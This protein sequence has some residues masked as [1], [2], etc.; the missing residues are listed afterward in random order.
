M[1]CTHR[2]E[3]SSPIPIYLG[4]CGTLIGIVIGVI[5]LGFGGGI[6]ALLTIPDTIGMAEDAAASVARE[7]QQLGAD[8]ISNLLRGI[9][10]AMTTTFCGVLLSIIGTINFRKSQVINEKNKNAFFSWIQAELLPKMDNSIASTLETLEKNL[11][12]FNSEFAGNSKGLTNIIGQIR[13]AATS[14]VEVYRQI[15]QL[16]I[17]RMANANVRVWQE[18]QNASDE[19]AQLHKFLF[20]SQQY[21]KHV[22]NLNDKLDENEGRTRLIEEMGQFFRTEIQEI[23]QRKVALSKSVGSVDD[24]MKTGLEELRKSIHDEYAKFVE[25]AG[26][27]QDKLSEAIDEQAQILSRKVEET[28]GLLDELKQLTSVKSAIESQSEAIGEQSEA[29]RKQSEAIV[30]M[31][32]QAEQKNKTVD[33]QTNLLR[34]ILQAQRTKAPAPSIPSTVQGGSTT[35][36]RQNL[37]IPAWVKVTGIATAAV[38]IGTCVVLLLAQFNII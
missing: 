5:M 2:L 25:V 14:Q 9:G 17:E 33:E 36:V 3:A 11:N 18:L 38:I 15:Q 7:S 12:K 35:I 30:N 34:Q 19:L 1:L 27:E 6:E 16:D 22:K 26:E 13:D 32:N 21:L 23:D 24:A 4:L 10:V 8:S 37:H 28:S 29:I 20:N 31:T